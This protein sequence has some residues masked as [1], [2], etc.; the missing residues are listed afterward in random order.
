MTSTVGTLLASA[1]AAHQQGRLQDAERQYQAV[2]AID[3][4]QTPALGLLGALMLQRND[5]VAALPLLEKALRLDPRQP[6][7]LNNHGHALY[8]LKRYDDALQS[9]D[10]ALAL[11]PEYAAAHN[12]RGTALRGL[13]RYEEALASF[14]E[15]CKIKPDFVDALNNLAGSLMDFNRYDEALAFYDRLISQNPAFTAALY[16]RAKA[17]ADLGRTEEALR[18]YDAVIAR[19]DRYANQSIMAKA[20]I[21]LLMGEFDD[22]WRLYETRWSPRVSTSPPRQFIQPLWRGDKSL[23]GKKILLHAEQGFGDTLQFC[24]YV[25][26]VQELGA[27]VIIIVQPELLTLL[28]PALTGCGIFTNGENLPSFDFHCPL[29]SLP[30]AFQTRVET[31]PTAVPYLFVPS[32]KQRQWQDRLGPRTKCRIGL[33]WSGRST[34]ANDRSRSISFDTLSGVLSCDAEFHC[35][36]N[37]IRT[38]DRAHPLFKKITIHDHA[39]TD[40][41]ETAA[42]VSEMDL[43]IAVDTSVAHLAGALGKPVW[44]L[45]PF[46]PDF[47]WLLA[48]ADSPWYPTAKLYRQHQPG[49]WADVIARLSHDLASLDSN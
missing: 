8:L 29:M 43:M 37:H 20:M 16:N 19:Q 42:L 15:A 4:G 13:K 30:L 18:D 32:E 46:A 27:K 2:L 31:I 45:L 14:K 1:V 39:L 21:K 41:L 34:H 44:V 22:G 24:R 35:L 36:Q 5:P 11:Q 40:F 25:P 17:L 7:T 28:T 33:I 3:S 49:D 6:S 10:A 38:Q 12:N 48:R 23:S 47:R 9:L 26:L